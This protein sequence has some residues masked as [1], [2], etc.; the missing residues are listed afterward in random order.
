MCWRRWW[1]VEDFIAVV[2]QQSVIGKN[3]DTEAREI[4]AFREPRGRTFAHPALDVQ[5]K[6]LE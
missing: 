2:A 1:R 6:G 4:D 5:G 3:G